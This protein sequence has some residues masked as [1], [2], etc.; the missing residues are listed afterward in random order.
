MLVVSCYF[1]WVCV[2]YEYLFYK[3]FDFCDVLSI[4]GFVVGSSEEMDFLFGMRVALVEAFAVFDV[5]SGILS[6]S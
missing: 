5:D 3:F 6:G 4:P 2:L 1:C